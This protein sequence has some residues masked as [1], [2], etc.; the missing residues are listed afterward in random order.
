M[1]RRALGPLLAHTNMFVVFFIMMMVMILIMC[2]RFQAGR[3][4]PR[5]AAAWRRQEKRRGM[6][7]RREER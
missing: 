3:L 5:P 2:D 7:E 6:E 1:V 4:T